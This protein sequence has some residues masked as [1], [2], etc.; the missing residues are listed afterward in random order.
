[1]LGASWGSAIA[2]V[3]YLIIPGNHSNPP[4]QNDALPPSP[5]TGSSSSILHPDPEKTALVPSGTSTIPFFP[6]TITL[7]PVPNSTSQASHPSTSATSDAL[8]AGLPTAPSTTDY[9]LL[10]LGIR[11]VTFLRIQVYVVGLYIATADL[12]ALQERMVRSIAG[13]GASTL[14]AHEKEDLARQLTDP[15]ASER[16][17]REV[18]SSP[19]QIR[20]VIRIV[21]TRPTDYGHLKEGWVRGLTA[22]GVGK[23]FEVKQEWDKRITEFKAIFGGRGKLGK[24][25]AMLLGRGADGGLGVWVEAA[26]EASKSVTEIQNA[27][28]AVGDGQVQ[29]KAQAVDQN[30]AMEYLGGVMD[31]R[32]GNLI[33]MGYV[34]GG[35]VASEGARK[36]V[37]AGVRELVERPV[38]TVETMVV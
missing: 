21:P 35:N 27:A 15:E 28:L 24:G 6:Q 7:P 5:T 8:P 31:P 29:K 17:W 9:Q 33:W 26:S 32:V 18:V 20:S 14:V 23:G 34:A 1:M 3:G 25:K 12:S 22:R 36:S 19:G 38:G 30:R 10:G 16:I 37:V 11:T 13:E 2:I 4:L